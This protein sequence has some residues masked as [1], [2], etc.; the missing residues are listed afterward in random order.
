MRARARARIV[1]V[2]IGAALFAS[3]FVACN[4][5]THIGDYN[6]DCSGCIAGQCRD[7]Y[8][9]CVLDAKC[10]TASGCFQ[11]CAQTGSIESCTSECQGDAGKDDPAGKMVTCIVENCVNLCFGGGPNPPPDSGGSDTTTSDAPIDGSCDI[12]ALPPIDMRICGAT[13]G[14]PMLG[15]STPPPALAPFCVDR[16]EVTID[17]YQ[18]FVDA[19]KDPCG[20]PP[21]CEWNTSYAAQMPP[22]PDGGARPGTLPV[23]GVDWC[24]AFMYCKWAGKH[25]CGGIPGGPSPSTDP[26]AD[27]WSFACMGLPPGNAYPYGASYMSGYCNDSQ[28]PPPAG[29]PEMVATRTICHG[30]SAPFTQIF[31]MSGN[32]AEW[33]DSCLITDPTHPAATDL[34]SVRGGAF[35]DHDPAIACAANVPHPRNTASG[36]IGFRC[37][38]P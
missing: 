22:P 36:A 27:Q 2:A 32:I 28:A 24:D 9:A 33:T 35:L 20:Q 14:N 12:G 15:M 6:V 5:L 34:C 19:V 16:T 3:P 13:R 30:T 29:H 7:Q 18:A 4:A 37:C 17:D 21:G 31:D 11:A 23:S 38:A 1:G 26:K 8:A 10:R 25:L